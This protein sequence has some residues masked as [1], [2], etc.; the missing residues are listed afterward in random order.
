METARSNIASPLTVPASRS[1]AAP[2]PDVRRITSRHQAPQPVLAYIAGQFPKRSETFVYREVRLLRERGWTVHC[3]SLRES[4][5]AASQEFADLIDNMT[6]VYGRVGVATFARGVKEMIQHPIASLRL[7]YTAMKDAITPKEK[8]SLT[9]RAKLLPQAMAAM[10]VSRH[11]RAIGVTHIHAHFAHAPATLAMYTARHMGVSFSFTG[12]ANDLFQRRALLKRKLSRAMFVA[13]ISQWHRQY[14]GTLKVDLLGKYHVIRCGVDVAGWSP[15][16]PMRVEPGVLH[17]LGVGRLVEKKGFDTLLRACHQLIDVRRRACH[18]TI[19]GDGE[20]RARLED[21][22]ESLGITQHVTWLGAVR[23]DRV[24]DLL[25]RAD[26]FALPCRTDARGDKDGIPV[27]LM[28]A[29]ARGV[30]A[31]SGDFPAIRELIEHG[32]DGLIVGPDDFVLL[33][34]HLIRLDTDEPERLRLAA[35]GRARVVEEFSLD[36]NVARLE[37]ALLNKLA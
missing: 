35:A 16:S 10:G 23:N 22:A 25:G 11:L 24:Q 17:V 13:C 37:E 18:L 5:D 32:H 14:Y 1:D 9:G 30:P 29:M 19:A 4:P 20:D 2:A 34:E 3:L 8:M 28:E 6:T 7:L 12:H 36:M 27:V 15:K 31:I 26:V 33:A 21:L